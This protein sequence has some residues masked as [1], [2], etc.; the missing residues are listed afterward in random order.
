MLALARSGRVLAALAVC[1]LPAGGLAAWAVASGGGEATTPPPPPPVNAPNAQILTRCGLSAETICA[2]G[3]TQGTQVTSLVDA[4]EV[5]IALDPNAL[6]NLDEDYAAKR[7]TYDALVRKVQSGLATAEEIAQ[8]PIAK[9][10]LDTA[11]TARESYKMGV[12]NAGL[13]TVS[14]TVATSVNTIWANR[15]WDELAVQYRVE[16]RSEAEWV[17]L[18]EALA[19]ERIAAQYSEPFPASTQSYL[20]GVNAGGAVSAAKVNL[21]TY[22]FAVQT[23]WNAAISS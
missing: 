14:P 10:E 22:L 13:A 16:N 20:A 8:L 7:V 18:R 23:A 12:R 3:V 15:A 6:T 4:A 11:D 19:T 21:D 2:A 9:G 5:V 17:A 1:L